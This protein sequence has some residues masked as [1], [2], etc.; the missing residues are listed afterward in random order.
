M[1]W[2]QEGFVKYLAT[3]ILSCLVC[4]KGW[5]MLKVRTFSSGNFLYIFWNVPFQVLSDVQC[6][7]VGWRHGI[8]VVAHFSCCK[9]SGA[10][11]LTSPEAPLPSVDLHSQYLIKHLCQISLL[12]IYDVQE[13]L[14]HPWPPQYLEQW[15]NPSSRAS[16]YLYAAS[17]S[18]FL[19]F[20]GTP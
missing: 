10:S 13:T 8:S 11:S 14:R 17:R 16:F 3:T 4:F 12:A 9:V 2:E 18:C 20:S 15:D 1:S 6:H 19:Y 7:W 5:Q